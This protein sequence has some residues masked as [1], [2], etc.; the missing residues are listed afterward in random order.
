MG[1]WADEYHLI[2][3]STAHQQAHARRLYW[4]L[5]FRNEVDKRTR[6]FPPGPAKQ[7]L[8]VAAQTLRQNVGYR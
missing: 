1:T 8:G 2:V 6:L 4:V 7:Y 5:G 3:R